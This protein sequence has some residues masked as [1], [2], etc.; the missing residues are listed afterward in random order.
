MKAYTDVEL[1]D[2]C[3]ILLLMLGNN[4]NKNILS[5]E[6]VG[7]FIPGSVMVQ[8][9]S[10]MTNTYMNK[11]GC[12]ILRKSSEELAAMGD[13]YFTRFFPEDEMKILIPEIIKFVKEGDANKVH[14]FFQRVRPNSKSDY[15][16]YLTT[17]RLYLGPYPGDSSK[18]FHVAIEAGK[19]SYAGRKL[20]QMIEDDVFVRKNYHLFKLLSL[21][22]KQI[23]RLIVG[24]ASSTAIADILFLSIYTVNNHRKNI[25]HK[26]EISCLSQLIKFAVSFNII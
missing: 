16:W 20:N 24:G 6:D 2:S 7:D 23:I 22:E 13:A 19:L 3:Q 14:S 26:L 18:I 5:I 21:R 10:T 4:I 17:S 12:D 15:T 25:L 1:K 8:D 11:S 9:L